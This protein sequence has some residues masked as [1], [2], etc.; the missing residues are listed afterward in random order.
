MAEK[1]TKNYMLMLRNIFSRNGKFLTYKT[2][3]EWEIGFKTN[4]SSC[5]FSFRSLCMQLQEHVH[6][7]NYG[8][9][10]HFR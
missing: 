6:V 9:L 5:N 8:V 2:N 7:F 1:K 3:V 10:F 4:R